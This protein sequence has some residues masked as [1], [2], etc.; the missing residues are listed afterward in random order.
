MNDVGFSR[1]G[2]G[3]S[4]KGVGFSPYIKT[5]QKQGLQPLRSALKTAPKK[6]T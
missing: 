3:F 4:R 1:N 2:T 5:N 6:C